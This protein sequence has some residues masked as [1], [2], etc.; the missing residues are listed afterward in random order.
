MSK[1]KSILE[2][3]DKDILDLTEEDLR[4]YEDEVTVK[5]NEDTLAYSSK[6][7]KYHNL[8]LILKKRTVDF[9]VFQKEAFDLKTE[10]ETLKKDM[11]QHQID[12]IQLKRDWERVHNVN[13]VK[14]LA[15]TANG[16]E[17]LIL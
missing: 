1:F 3:S 6:R 17:A 4:H 9:A 13:R 5:V 2:L 16:D 12:F 11:A 7:E 8:A 10:M 15:R 14:R